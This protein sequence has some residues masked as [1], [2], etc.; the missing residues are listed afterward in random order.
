MRNR[1]NERK[2]VK[3][4]RLLVSLDDVARETRPWWRARHA[5]RAVLGT[6]RV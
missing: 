3:L 1:R 2:A 5:Q 6:T 4:A